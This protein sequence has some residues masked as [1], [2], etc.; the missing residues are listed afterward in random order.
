MAAP[1]PQVGGQACKRVS[2]PYSAFDSST[3]CSVTGSRKTAYGL[4][5]ACL[6]DLTE[7]FANRS[8][9]TPYRLE[10]SCAAAPKY[11]IAMDGLAGSMP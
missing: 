10:Y 3:S 1:A 7:I 5:A 11:C 8:G 9:E 2:P 6:R 4:L